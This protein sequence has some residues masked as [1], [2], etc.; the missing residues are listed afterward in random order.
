MTT[1]TC[2]LETEVSRHLFV[3]KSAAQS[4]CRRFFT[5]NRA[6]MI[7]ETFS[8]ACLL[9]LADQGRSRRE[10]ATL[11]QYVY[12]MV[13]KAAGEVA[14][15]KHDRLMSRLRRLPP[16]SA[17]S[18]PVSVDETDSADDALQTP[19]QVR[20]ALEGLSERLKRPLVMR[21]YD[22]MATSQIATALGTTENA[23]NIS[24][25]RGRKVLRGR[26]RPRGETRPP[27]IRGCRRA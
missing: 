15:R 20:A 18:A 27:D 12:A 13:L 14:D 22:G 7:E 23:V 5:R 11:D 21:Y 4:V 26:L 16:V 9:M 17:T 19:E 2:D 25:C 10:D 1:R 3:I 24:M 6:E 8:Q